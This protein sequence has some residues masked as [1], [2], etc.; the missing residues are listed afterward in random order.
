MYRILLVGSDLNVPSWWGFHHVW[1]G[2]GYR[3]R[4]KLEKDT[5]KIGKKVRMRRGMNG[6]Q[7]RDGVWE[8]YAFDRGSPLPGQVFRQTRRR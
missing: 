3:K 8:E 7:K 4:G 5:G 1:G 6:R 2:S